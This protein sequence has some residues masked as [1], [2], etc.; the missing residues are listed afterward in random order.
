MDLPSP[1]VFVVDDEPSVLK[2]TARLLRATGMDAETFGSAQAFL[3]CFD[4][5]RPGCLLLDLSMPGLDGLAL[6]QFLA[7]RGIGLPVVFLSGRGDIPATVRA[8]RQGAVDFLTKPVD[9]GDLL[10]ALRRALEQDRL[11]RLA[12]GCAAELRARFAALTAREHQV[13]RNVIA[14][15]LNKQ[16]AADLG[17]TEKTVKVHRAH[18]MEKLAVASLPELTRLAQQAGIEPAVGQAAAVPSSAPAS[19]H[20]A[21][22]ASP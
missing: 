11:A 10:A 17:V 22:G 14:G 21:A 3:E 1:R 4:P 16:I 8:M 13:L 15:R 5:E 9:P 7:S 19:P 18:I 12:G 20:G 6:Q 2:S